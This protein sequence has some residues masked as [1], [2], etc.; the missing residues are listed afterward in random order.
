MIIN[1]CIQ[2]SL[3]RIS[4][5]CLR[6][7]D[8][9]IVWFDGASN[10]LGHGIGVVLVSPD[11]Q[12][13][14]F[15]AKLCFDCTNNIAEYKACVLGIWAAIDFRVKLLKVYGDL[16]LV[17]HQ[18]KGEWET[19]DHKLVPYIEFRCR[20]EP[21][22]CCFIEE[23]EDDKPWY[24]DI[25]RY[26]ED[27]EY[28]P[29]ASDNGKRT[30]WRFAAGFLLS[31]NILYKRKHDMVLLRCVDARETKQMLVEVHE[32]S[33]GTHANEH[34]MARKI[35]RVGYYWLTVENNCCIQ[36]RKCH[37]CQTF[38]NNV[39]A[40]PVPLNVLAASWSFSM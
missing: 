10:A 32:G 33:F 28:S 18:L 21:A 37:K 6:T 16:V 39:N 22:H 40:P 8:K 25:K 15:T 23:D 34:A 29:K 14:P 27:K 4:W 9:W 17:I 13:I 35:F 19:R 38:A 7:R 31:E 1:L 36:V 5:P 20:G 11:K 3:T 30:L 12:Y 24:F 2:N 26:I